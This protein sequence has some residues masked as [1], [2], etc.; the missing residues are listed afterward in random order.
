[1]TR[2]ERKRRSIRSMLDLGSCRRGRLRLRSRARLG[3][4]V[5]PRSHGDRDA[6]A[7]EDADASPHG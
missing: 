4:L 1:M 6:R 5:K 2:T 3:S 7:D